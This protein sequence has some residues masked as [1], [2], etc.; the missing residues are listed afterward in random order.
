M[1]NTTF[2]LFWR[3]SLRFR[4]S[5]SRGKV[6]S[7]ALDRECLGR[8]NTSRD[9]TSAN[10]FFSYGMRRGEGISKFLPSIFMLL[11]SF[12]WFPG[13]WVIKPYR[14]LPLRCLSV[15][16][17]LPD[18]KVTFCSL[19]GYVPKVFVSKVHSEYP[20][21][22]SLLIYAVITQVGQKIKLKY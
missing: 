19:T 10:F 3:D 4:C 17:S 8:A 11:C 2:C 9:H 16:R 14:M 20:F 12:Q 15:Q 13:T 1:T 7:G 21:Q 6:C 18:S 22:N 5:T